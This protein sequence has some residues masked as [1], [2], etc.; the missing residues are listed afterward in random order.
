MNSKLYYAD[1]EKRRV[2]FRVTVQGTFKCIQNLR[3]FPFDRQGL[4][5]VMQLGLEINSRVRACTGDSLGLCMKKRRRRRR[6]RKTLDE[7]LALP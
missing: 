1:L 5:L 6:T 7:I 4:K 2:G 3:A